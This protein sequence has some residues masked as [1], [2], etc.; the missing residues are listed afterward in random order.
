MTTLPEDWVSKFCFYFHCL[1]E[2]KCGVHGEFFE[3]GV[4]NTCLPLFPS[5]PS[6]VPWGGGE[7]GRVCG[8]AIANLN[9]RDLWLSSGHLVGTYLRGGGVWH[10]YYRKK[11]L[12]GPF[13]LVITLGPPTESISK[14]GFLYFQH[15]WGFVSLGK[16]RRRKSGW[17]INYSWTSFGSFEV[18]T[19]TSPPPPF[20]SRVVAIGIQ[21]CWK[22][23]NSDSSLLPLLAYQGKKDIVC[24]FIIEYSSLMAL[25]CQ[26]ISLEWIHCLVVVNGGLVKKQWIHWFCC[27]EWG[28]VKKQWIHWF[29][30]QW[31]M[32]YTHIL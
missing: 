3:R 27:S 30:E 16:K 31:L 28:P 19:P 17:L 20:L 23:R 18:S 25:V 4:W 13:G 11:E 9:R 32:N 26:V 10:L 29:S 8:R 14:L 24:R 15:F 12:C 7:R 5:L 21:K 6:L 1:G 2:S 22:L